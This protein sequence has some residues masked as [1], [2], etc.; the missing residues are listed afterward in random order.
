MSH[1]LLVYELSFVL[2]CNVQFTFCTSITRIKRKI[3]NSPKSQNTTILC[4]ISRA[5]LYNWR[6][7]EESR[8][9]F[10]YKSVDWLKY[11]G[12]SFFARSCD[13]QTSASWTKTNQPILLTNRIWSQRVKIPTVFT[14]AIKYF[15]STIAVRTIRSYFTWLAGSPSRTRNF[16]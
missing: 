4:C 12:W 6:T 5:T 14:D 11:L 15:H 16:P 9:A 7:R 3:L 13:H 1:S 2:H 8:L 10:E